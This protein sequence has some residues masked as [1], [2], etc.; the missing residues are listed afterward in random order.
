MD[1]GGILVSVVILVLLGLGIYYYVT[2]HGSSDA[3]ENPNMTTPIPTIHDGRKSMTYSDTL[4]KSFNQPDGIAM[5]YAGWIRVDDFTYRYG[6]P[7]VIFS[8]GDSGAKHPCPA[9]LIDGKTNGF[10]VKVDTFGQP[11]IISVQNIPAKKWI[12]FAITVD[13]DS[14]N[15]YI[16]GTL[17]S[18]NTLTNLPKQNT[19]PLYI[20]P[21]GGFD[22]KIG[23][24][25]YYNYTLSSSAVSALLSTAPQQDP[26]ESG[27]GPLPPY[28]DSTWWTH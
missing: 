18:Y 24:L 17:A 19:M 15:V 11:E 13:Q 2:K 25:E 28:L 27:I 3:P 8:K 5:S 4:P 23:K 1:I 22:G 9:L 12:H 26:S 7:K 20:S 14:V 21:D 10:M 16:N 6:V